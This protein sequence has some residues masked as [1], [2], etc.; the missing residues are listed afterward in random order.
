MDMSDKEIDD[1]YLME[2]L[3]ELERQMEQEKAEKSW[4]ILEALFFWVLFL[5]VAYEF[6]YEL[7]Q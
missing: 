4:G 5:G 1:L 6:W 3:M 7:G 2:D